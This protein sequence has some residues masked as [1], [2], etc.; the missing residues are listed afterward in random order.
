MLSDTAG[1]LTEVTGS[2]TQKQ[3]AQLE[4]AVITAG[5]LAL[6][7]AGNVEAA[8]QNAP[9]GL[10]AAQ[11][12]LTSEGKQRQQAVAQASASELRQLE[13]LSSATS[14]VGC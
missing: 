1:L 8:E 12:E 2:M 5:N 6:I 13:S 4:T 14:N 9:S 10:S 7:S 3:A 11:P